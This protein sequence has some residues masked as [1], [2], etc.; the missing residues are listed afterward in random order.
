MIKCLKVY[1]YYYNLLTT[2][3]IVIPD[4]LTDACADEHRHH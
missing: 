3:Y 4:V 2:F 1:T